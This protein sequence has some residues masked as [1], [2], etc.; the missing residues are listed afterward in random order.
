MQS[1]NILIVDDDVQLTTM[2]SSVLRREKYRPVVCHSTE[3]AAGLAAVDQPD[4]TIVDMLM[5]SKSGMVSIH[6][7]RSSY[8]KMK[9]IG[10]SDGLFGK[11]AIQTATKA[12]ADAVLCKPFTME[13]FSSCLTQILAIGSERPSA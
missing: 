9:I 4:L 13:E 7:L 12:G 1:R 10:L 11:S 3:A 5:P 6:S 8:P 2:L